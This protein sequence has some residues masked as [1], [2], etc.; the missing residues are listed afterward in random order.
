MGRI[1]GIVVTILLVV[2]A[3]LAAHSFGFLGLEQFLYMGQ[4]LA[5]WLAWTCLVAIIY[6]GLEKLFPRVLC[7]PLTD[8]SKPQP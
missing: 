6:A 2:L 4:L 3:M 7:P 5:G 1:I 8:D